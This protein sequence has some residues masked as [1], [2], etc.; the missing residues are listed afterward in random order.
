MLGGSESRKKKKEKP[1]TTLDGEEIARGYPCK[2]RLR[3]M[4]LGSTSYRL[5][6]TTGGIPG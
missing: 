2:K 3:M 6:R 4:L 1:S 5:S